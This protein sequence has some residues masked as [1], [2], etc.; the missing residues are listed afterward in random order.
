MSKRF[1]ALDQRNREI[2]TAL[3]RGEPID[4]L[5]RRFLLSER[6]VR[7]L[8]VG[9][10]TQAWTPWSAADIAVVQAHYGQPGWSAQRIAAVL[11]RTR[12]EVIG[13]AR[14]LGLSDPSW[15]AGA[16]LRRAQRQQQIAD[17]RRQQHLSF[18]AIARQL[19]VPRGTVTAE[20]FR[21][22]MQQPGFCA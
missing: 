6:Y 21:W 13:K 2:R 4:Q 8:G 22:K 3:A 5:A 17:L 15:R 10:G 11:G 1:S 12:N 18:D 19:G 7:D 16:S 9:L 20:Y 14:R